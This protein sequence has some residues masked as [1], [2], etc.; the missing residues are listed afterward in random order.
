[1]LSSTNFGKFVLVAS[2]ISISPVHAF[3]G[4]LKFRHEL[5]SL[6][7][8]CKIAE[9]Q[10]KW[11]NSLIPTKEEIIDARNALFFVGGWSKFYRDNQDI[12]NGT[13]RRIV[14][15]KV[16]EIIEECRN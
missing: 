6:K 3:E 8:D 16:R 2:L 10:I 12:S 7:T 11:L 4:H 5:Y 9:Q 14:N 13:I 15:Q 1:M